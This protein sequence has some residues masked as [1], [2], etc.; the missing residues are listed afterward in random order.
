MAPVEADAANIAARSRRSVR[1][2]TIEAVIPMTKA[3]PVRRDRLPVCRLQRRR[4][5]PCRTIVEA[6]GDVA[7]PKTV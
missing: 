6:A 2:S 7:T 5:T 1:P 3:E 4:S